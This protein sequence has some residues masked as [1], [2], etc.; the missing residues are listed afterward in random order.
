MTMADVQIGDKTEWFSPRCEGIVVD[1]DYCSVQIRWDDGTTSIQAK[2]DGFIGWKVKA[3]QRA[4][5]PGQHE[6]KEGQQ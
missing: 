4:G 6:K 2:A 1:V 3:F 5:T